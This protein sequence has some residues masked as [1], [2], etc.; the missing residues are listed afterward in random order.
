MPR[1]YA[2]R[3]IEQSIED[4]VS[5]D[6]DGCVQEWSQVV[7][8][9]CVCDLPVCLAKRVAKPARAI[10]LLSNPLLGIYRLSKDAL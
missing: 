10:E 5:R 6:L 9:P 7:V 1:F 8:A 3:D 4:L 2:M